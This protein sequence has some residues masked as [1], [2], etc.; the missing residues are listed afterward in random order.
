MFKW[1][2]RLNENSS[3]LETEPPATTTDKAKEVV[4][5]LDEYAT[6]INSL[7]LKPYIRY[8]EEN[9]EHKALVIKSIIQN[10]DGMF[11][12]FTKEFGDVRGFV[13]EYTGVSAAVFEYEMYIVRKSVVEKLKQDF[14]NEI[15]GDIDCPSRLGIMSKLLHEKTYL[16]HTL[17]VFPAID[18]QIIYWRMG[19]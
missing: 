13:E 17:K 1:I 10:Y 7:Y 11:P 3:V 12:E 18:D 16:Y 2:K 4:A 15:S 6:K 8:D 19:V 9:P 5:I 14:K